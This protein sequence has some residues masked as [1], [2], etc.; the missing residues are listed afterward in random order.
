MTKKEKKE[1]IVLGSK[2]KVNAKKLQTDS[3]NKVKVSKKEDTSKNESKAS[4]NSLIAQPIVEKSISIKKKTK[5][6]YKNGRTVS[7]T[8]T[9]STLTRNE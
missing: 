6:M 2:T 5:K 4:T 9:E 3:G 8:S 1:D 7:S